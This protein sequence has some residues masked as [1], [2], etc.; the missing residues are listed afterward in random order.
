MRPLRAFALSTATLGLAST[1][2][3]QCE[4]QTL[5]PLGM[6][7]GGNFGRVSMDDQFLFVGNP[8]EP[9]LC[10]DPFDCATG[11]LHVFQLDADGL[12]QRTQHIVPP[13]ITL[14]S[15]FGGSFSRDG[16]RLLVGAGGAMV[17][18]EKSGKA[19]LYEYDGQQWN[20]V[21]QFVPREPRFL[22]GFGGSATLR[23]DAALFY[24][25]ESPGSVLLYEE[26]SEGWVFVDEVVS[27][28][29]ASAGFGGS[30]A[31]HQQWVF[32]GA[33]VDDTEVDLGGSVFVYRRVPGEGLEFVQRIIPP[34]IASM[35][36]FGPA[37]GSTIHLDGGTLAI[38]GRGADRTYENQGVIYLYELRD[39]RWQ[40]TQE[41]TH[42]PAGENHT[43]GI[44]MDLDGDTLIAGTEEDVWLQTGA[45]YVFRRGPDGVW[46]QAARIDPDGRLGR[47]GLGV[48]TNG[49]RAAVSAPDAFFGGFSVGLVHAYDLACFDCAPD[50]DLDGALTIY[51]FLSFLNLFED[52]E[53][54]ADFDGDGELTVF[55]FLAF[56]D[57]FQ[58]GCP[59]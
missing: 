47:F 52:G 51:D 25:A 3:A 32:I 16:D 46:S 26:S 12:W 55:D 35:P 53:A 4:P 6:P 7:E 41:L 27:P 1:V 28:L 50:L 36:R 2:L 39:D 20:E 9:T 13:D 18:G 56:Q 49:N 22:L 57:A 15:G 24:Q 33:S 48:A 54:A 37:F 30:I 10:P 29:P 40:L 44:R 43:L 45:A 8:G 34:D 14:A 58:A 42:E 23:D 19:Y 59:E 38:A 31:M 17:D 5:E 11:A 21:Y